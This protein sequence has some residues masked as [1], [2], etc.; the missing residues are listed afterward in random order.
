M[1]DGVLRPVEGDPESVRALAGALRAG[2]T[3]LAQVNEVLAGIRAGASWDSPAG[4]VFEAAVQQSPP[5]VDALVDRYAGAAVALATFADAL[6]EVQARARSAG[7]DHRAALADHRRLEE[8]AVLHHGD[9]VAAELTRRRLGEAMGRV[10]RAERAH[11]R[12]WEDFGTADRHLARRL[13]TLADD[14]LD[15]PWHYSAFA[16]GDSAAAEAAAIPSLARRSSVLGSVGVAG[17]VVGTVSQVGLLVFYG[18]GSWKQVGVNATSATVGLGARGLRRGSL[19]GAGATSRLA[20]RS[21]GY[22][23]EPL[24]ARQRFLI[25]TREELHRSQPRLAR[26]LDGRTPPS[27]MVVPL[28]AL[29]PMPST[30]HLPLGQRAQVWRAQA[31]VLVRRRADEAFLDDWRAATAGGAVAQRM[32]VGGV[33]LQRVVPA[34]REGTAGTPPPEQQSITEQAPAQQ[35]PARQD[36]ARQDPA[37]QEDARQDHLTGR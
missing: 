1:I 27:R 21:R 30:K 3:R 33:T 28:D 11:A 29:P 13:R 24:S 19:S 15:D 35:P 22:A 23:G 32:F 12:A 18:E 37:R 10:L 25:G 7:E 8:E 9:P 26:A 4:E 36:P 31:G 34:V 6:E 20:D 14:I 2:A 5:V 17:A 16:A